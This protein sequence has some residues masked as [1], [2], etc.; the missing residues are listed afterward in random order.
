MRAIVATTKF[1]VAQDIDK[2]IVDALEKTNIFYFFFFFRSASSGD[3]WSDF[4]IKQLH[5]ASEA[6]LRVH[7][8]NFK[9]INC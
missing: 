4:S 2:I 5:E 1:T 3:I 9:L 7:K 6:S 8:D